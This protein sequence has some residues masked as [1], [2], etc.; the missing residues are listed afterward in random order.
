MPVITIE[1][2]EQAA[3]EIAQQRFADAQAVML[4]GSIIRGEAT[5]YSDLD[6]VV[7]Y[8]EVESAWRES[9]T[10]GKWPVEAFVHDEGTLK[11]FFDDDARCGVPSLPRMV[12]EGRVIAGSADFIQRLKIMAKDVI[13]AGPRVLTELEKRRKRYEISDVVDDI[14]DPRSPAELTASGSRLYSMLAEFYF[15]ANNLWAA[16]GKSVPRRLNE[17]DEKL[18]NRFESAFNDLFTEHDPEPVIEL[19]GDLLAP[20]GGFLFDD[21]KMQAPKEWRRP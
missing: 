5:K 11:Y 20:H 13:D 3:K 17:I 18:A 14:R 4:G 2:A 12:W 8:E 10:H 9:F 21:Y 16:A 15:R 6:I 19:A 7:V 1:A